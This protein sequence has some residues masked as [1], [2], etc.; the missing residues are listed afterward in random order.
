MANQ[1]KVQ[2]NSHLSPCIIV[3]ILGKAVKND[4]RLLSVSW[5][6]LQGQL[7]ISTTEINGDRER[8]S[9]KV[10]KTHR[11]RASLLVE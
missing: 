3:C 7:N 10:E 9:S 8:G 2:L 4:K 5:Y 11:K 6:V 1:F